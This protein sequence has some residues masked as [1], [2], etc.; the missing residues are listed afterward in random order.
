MTWTGRHRHKVNRTQSRT[1]N[2]WCA[3]KARCQNPKNEKYP[4]YGGRGIRVC[5]RWQ[6]FDNFLADMGECPEGMTIDREHNDDNYEPGRCRWAT[7]E[8]QANKR[9]NNHLITWNDKTQ[10]IAQW[11]QELGMSYGKLVSRIHREWPLHLAMNPAGRR[12][13][14]GR[15]PKTCTPTPKLSCAECSKPFVA[16]MSSA[17]FCSSACRKRCCKRE[18]CQANAER[19]TE[20]RRAKM[21]AKRAGKV[22]KLTRLY[23]ENNGA[24]KLSNEQ[25][26][27]I[28][29]RRSAG[30]S[31]AVIAVLFGISKATVNRLYNG[32]TRGAITR[33]V[34]MHHQPQRLET[35]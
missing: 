2:S 33:P 21:A 7:D 25:A 34:N 14:I 8:E 5:E 35:T 10:T 26:L 29:K 31:T 30:E 32:K 11:A 17:R 24:S 19:E 28:V 16:K 9:S 18:W 20:K 23:G 15:A 3:M 6:L 22:R 12:K 27:D 4:R 13:R 1:Y